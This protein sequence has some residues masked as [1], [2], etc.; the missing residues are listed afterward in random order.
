MREIQQEI[1]R[2][3]IVLLNHLLRDDK[4]KSAIISGLAVLIIKGEKG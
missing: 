4:Y 1:L 3:C 2:F